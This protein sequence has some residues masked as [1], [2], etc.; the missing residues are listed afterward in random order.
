MGVPGT[1]FFCLQGLFVV[2]EGARA[3]SFEPTAKTEFARYLG[4]LLSWEHLL[5]MDRFLSL[6]VLVGVSLLLLW[7]VL[8]LNF[9]S[10]GLNFV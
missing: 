9:V 7:E 3:S 5:F 4:E 2:A 6:V 1:E 8:L 10:L